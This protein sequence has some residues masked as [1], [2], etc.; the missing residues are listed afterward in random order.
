MKIFVINAGSSSIKY[1]LF[2]MPATSPVC[3]GQVENIGGAG[4]ASHHDA[5]EQ[6]LAELSHPERGCIGSAD[7]I[8]VVGH[9]IVHGGEAFSAATIIDEPAR[10]KIQSLFKLAP[11]HNPVN[12]LC[13]TLA[14]EKF[15]AARHIAIFDTAFHTTLPP[16]AYRYAI[17]VHLY[18]DEKIR[19]YGFHGTSHKYVSEAASKYLGSVPE[20]LISIHLGNGSSITAIRNGKSIDTSMGF[21]PL[22]GLIMGTR[23]G[24][25]DGSVIFHLAEKV[26]KSI[27]EI[28]TLLNRDSGMKALGGSND[29]R[30]L[31]QKAEGGDVEAQLALLMYAYRVKKYIGAYVAAMNGV[32]AII[33]TAGIGENDALTRARICENMDYLGIIID[34]E[35]NLASGKEL[36]EIQHNTS[37]VKI[38]VVPT[39]EEL[40]I[41]RQC[42]H[43][44]QS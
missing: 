25:I 36:R 3:T 28:R 8:E 44:A 34:K 37:K 22:A 13:L 11:L 17:P 20:R 41:A 29:M 7:E 43:L 42:Y 14:E 32:E 21:G 19:V 1:Q 35:R 2:D 9:R 39:N 5:M 16:E 27:D 12:Y 24:D 30:V 31:N 38:L 6:I 15:P 10:E 4:T 40:E 18:K 33:F 23:S 26:G